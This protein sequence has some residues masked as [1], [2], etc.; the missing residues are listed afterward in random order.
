MD[1]NAPTGSVDQCAAFVRLARRM[2]IRAEVA[3]PQ[4]IERTVHSPARAD[5][6][7]YVAEPLSA[8]A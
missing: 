8:A 3:I 1:M 2:N 7:A 5:I 6:R 4:Y